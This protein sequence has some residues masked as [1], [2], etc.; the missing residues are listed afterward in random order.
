M[1]TSTSSK[2]NNKITKKLTERERASLSQVMEESDEEDE[3]LKGP[4]STLSQQS[5]TT[6]ESS[7][8]G[9]SFS[10]SPV[11][12]LT[13]VEGKSSKVS[14]TKAE[15]SNLQ[16]KPNDKDVD[17]DDED[18]AFK[19][20]L[21]MTK[22]ASTKQVEDISDPSLLRWHRV[23][24]TYTPCCIRTNQDEGKDL[25][26]LN[27]REDTLIRYLGFTVS[28]SG[29]LS[30]ASSKSLLPFDYI[31]QKL[32]SASKRKMPL[33]SNM[34]EKS[35]P[36]ED[37]E[38]NA[39]KSEQG[40]KSD[41]QGVVKVAVNNNLDVGNDERKKPENDNDIIVDNGNGQ[42]IESDNN[43][44]ETHQWAPVVME[45]YIK[46][47]KGRKDMSLAKAL[48]EKIVLE[49]F[50]TYVL[51]RFKKVQKEQEKK[52]NKANDSTVLEEEEEEKIAGS[53]NEEGAENST[54]GQNTKT[55]TGSREEG[56]KAPESAVAPS[57]K[58]NGSDEKSEKCIIAS[59]S[60]SKTYTE[61]ERK[62]KIKLRAGD[63]IEYYSPEAVASIESK[64]RATIVKVIPGDDMP[65][66]LN[67]GMLVEQGSQIRLVLRL[68]RGSL[69]PS[70]FTKWT[71]LETFALDSSNN[72]KV[73]S[74]NVAASLVGEAYE[75]ACREVKEEEDGFWRKQAKANSKTSS[76][77]GNGKDEKIT[78]NGDDN[79][80]D[81]DDDDAF[82]KNAKAKKRGKPSLTK[83]D[84][85][86]KTQ[87]S[88]SSEPNKK[89]SRSS[90]FAASYQN[91]KS[92]LAKEKGR[93]PVD[94]LPDKKRKLSV[95]AEKAI[96]LTTAKKRRRSSVEKI[97]VETPVE[98]RHPRIPRKADLEQKLHALEKKRRGDQTSILIQKSQIQV[99]LECWVAIL[100]IARS[101]AEYAKN[102]DALLDKLAKKFGH[103]LDNVWNFL[104]GNKNGLLIDETLEKMTK[105]WNDW[106]L[107][108]VKEMPAVSD[109]AAEGS[110]EKNQMDT[111][112]TEQ[113]EFKPVDVNKSGTPT[114]DE[115]AS[116]SCAPKESKE[117]DDA[118]AT[119][120]NGKDSSGNKGFQTKKEPVETKKTRGGNDA[121]KEQQDDAE[122]DQDQT[123]VSTHK[124]EKKKRK[125]SLKREEDITPLPPNKR[126]SISSNS[127]TVEPVVVVHPRIPR[128]EELTTKLEMLHKK[129]RG[130]KASIAI[131]KA[132]I[133][134]TI[135]CWKHVLNVA[136]SR[137]DYV[138]NLDLLISDLAKGFKRPKDTLWNFLDGNKNGLLIDEVLV[139]MTKE[140]EDWMMDRTKEASSRG[141]SV[142]TEQRVSV[143]GTTDPTTTESLPTS[144]VE[145][146]PSD[147]QETEREPP[148]DVDKGLELMDG[149]TGGERKSKEELAPVVSSAEE[150]QRKE[151]DR[152][153]SLPP[154]ESKNGESQL[155]ESKK[156]AALLP[157]V[158]KQGHV[159]VGSATKERQGVES[160]T[161]TSTALLGTKS[162]D[163][164]E[165]DWKKTTSSL[166]NE[167]KSEPQSP[168]KELASTTSSR[169]EESKAM[170]REA[171]KGVV[172]KDAG[173]NTL[174]DSL[175]SGIKQPTEADGTKPAKELEVNVDST[176]AES[177]ENRYVSRED[178]WSNVQPDSFT[179][180]EAE[181]PNCFEC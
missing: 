104:D 172:T 107:D 180:N 67:D 102:L 131:Q 89:R 130:D 106:L 62:G 175:A 10:A 3:L 32:N 43:H 84:T 160:E 63:V 165:K 73:D 129:R 173:K 105:E 144:N 158:L 69:Q 113:A 35:V 111:K 169:P 147:G 5:N 119:S 72:G 70:D 93:V 166:S 80:M 4:A 21:K 159:P 81:C 87:G 1:N 170:S 174:V 98:V 181:S 149:E 120:G 48:A 64:R 46:S 12:V 13:P 145:A 39:S 90:A 26:N 40:D 57:A 132:H 55:K 97:P 82:A 109:A 24:S 9:A 101:R 110:G 142:S 154:E 68:L 112:E 33:S 16:A 179:A 92:P 77:N 37:G 17:D 125:R 61:K 138:E 151:S 116:K 29:A 140:W 100:E 128:K 103:S 123:V 14:D 94:G 136:R 146:K 161:A 137:A 121:K 91:E 143:P 177:N 47:I 66:V 85:L 78:G 153:T 124:S 56:E 34:L 156:I 99:V 60:T 135:A 126:N 134:T 54:K 2:S 51:E 88:K 42:T 117:V 71:C 6:T 163:N 118:A 127:L 65:L 22:H 45:Q 36:E 162:G 95:S 38:N 44:N 8:T 41:E 133:E 7:P 25:V 150:S 28:P 114:G 122:G 18:Q 19:D 171:G 15:T 157:D 79:K 74:K 148:A 152:G 108:H 49:R 59:D 58:V 52:K 76:E 83:L 96:D 50:L 164:H 75:K 11:V 30:V 141:M 86:A 115:I 23:K 27:K 31:P 176:K 178:H 20:A 168:S 155:K 139:L 167:S 53:K